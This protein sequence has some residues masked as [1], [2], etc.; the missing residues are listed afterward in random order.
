MDSLDG[1]APPQK[2]SHTKRVVIHS[3][4]AISVAGALVAMF[5]TGASA[6]TGASIAALASLLGLVSA[7]RASGQDANEVARR[8][9]LVV[10]ARDAARQLEELFTMTDMLQAAEDFED[11]SAVLMRT[12]EHLLPGFAGALYVFRNSR[13]R[14]DLAQAWGEC[15]GFTPGTTLRPQDCWA[16]KRGKPHINSSEAGTLCCQHANEDTASVEIPMIARGQVHGLLILAIADH[17]AYAQLKQIER[18][19]RALADSVSLAFSNITLR[20]KLRT[21]SLRDPL[22]GLYNRRY[23]EDALERFVH[24]ARRNGSPTCLIMID[25]DNFKMLNDEF[26]HAKGDAILRDVSA[27]MVGAVR[28]ADVVSR[29][30]GE[31]FV[32]ILPECT[33]A[34]A[35]TRAEEIRVRINRLSDLHGASVSASLGVSCLPTTCATRIELIA[36][37]DQALYRAKSAGKNR[38]IAAVRSAEP[39]V[40]QPLP[41]TRKTT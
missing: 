27:Q 36:S 7:I 5:A 6:F 16:L 2:P 39:S 35:I 33:L 30:G 13:D 41:L 29:F 37:A 28:P 31:E 32:V 18:I 4:Q 20:E 19:A 38:V 21:Q 1:T 14:L 17:D 26:G 8:G 10:K 40:P 22:T 9:E 23:M 11:A 3:I 34:D 12:A 15:P 25:L 24:L